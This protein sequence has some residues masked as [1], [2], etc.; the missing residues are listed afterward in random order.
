MRPCSPV[1]VLLIFSAWRRA[2]LPLP[3]NRASPAAAAPGRNGS[4]PGRRGSRPKR[5][6]R[7]PPPL[8]AGVAP[9]VP[10]PRHALCAR[11][12]RRRR[13]PRGGGSSCSSRRS[14][15]PV[16]AACRQPARHGH[17]HR[18]CVLLPALLSTPFKN[19]VKVEVENLASDL[20]VDCRL[21]P[22]EMY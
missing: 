6:R 3:Q 16:Q 5:E 13:Q 4:A 1:R 21:L 15:P 12:R 11:C 20:L 8:A 19:V 17:H 9:A 2:P 10:V 14:S 18:R 22:H 7:R